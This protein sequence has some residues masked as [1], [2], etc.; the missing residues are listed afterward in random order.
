MQANVL[1]NFFFIPKG[2]ENGKGKYQSPKNYNIV[3]GKYKENK[4]AINKV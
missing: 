3:E 2:Q 4:K 1:S